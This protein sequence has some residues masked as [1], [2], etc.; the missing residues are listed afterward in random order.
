MV[1]LCRC[2]ALLFI[3]L[4]TCEDVFCV[5]CSVMV[6]WEYVSVECRVS[7]MHQDIGSVVLRPA[8]R[9]VSQV[10][11]CILSIPHARHPAR[12]VTTP[13]VLL[14]CCLFTYVPQPF[15]SF[16]LCFIGRG[17][18]PMPPLCSCRAHAHCLYSLSC[19]STLDSST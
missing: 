12:N 3:G 9:T 13:S 16:F 6:G 4:H 19:P 11:R 7:R 15:G 2:R 17:S 18:S 14:C 10:F 1:S 8:F 5:T